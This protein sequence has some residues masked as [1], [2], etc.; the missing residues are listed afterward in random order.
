MRVAQ[1]HWR[2]DNSPG[3]FATKSSQKRL[4]SRVWDKAMSE[5]ALL[6]SEPESYVVG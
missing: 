5:S 6:Y 4:K 2:R 1:L 3:R